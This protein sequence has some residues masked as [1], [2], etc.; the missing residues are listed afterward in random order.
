MQFKEGTEIFTQKGEAVGK[1]SRVVIDPNTKEITHLIVEKGLFFPDDRVVP[2]GQ[3]QSATEDRVVLKDEISLQD[4]PPFEVT[5][6]VG[7]ESE[8][9]G[10][11]AGYPASGF[12][13]AFYWYPPM[14]YPGY[15]GYPVPAYGPGFA[16]TETERNIPD[17]TVPLKDGAEVVSRDGR[18]VGSVEQVIA[19]PNTMKTTHFVISQGLLFKDR[20]MIPVHWLDSVDEEHVYLSVESGLLERLPAYES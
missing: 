7:A 14:G 12:V 8:T 9:P 15:V 6:F 1:V 19:D 16:Q 11:A 10:T 2:A 18:P 17:D 20:K 4:L 3:I 13:P 5:H